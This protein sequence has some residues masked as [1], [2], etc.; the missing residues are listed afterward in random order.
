MHSRNEEEKKWPVH[1]SM[2]TSYLSSLFTPVSLI[3]YLKTGAR[4]KWLR[5]CMQYDSK[6]LQQKATGT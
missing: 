2:M 6:E 3:D 4:R 1:L 5:I